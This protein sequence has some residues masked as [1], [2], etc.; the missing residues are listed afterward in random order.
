MSSDTYFVYP[1]I[2]LLTVFNQQYN[3]L[4]KM[5]NNDKPNFDTFAKKDY[6]SDFCQKKEEAPIQRDTL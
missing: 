6:L 1:A 3:T 4:P 5:P 2:F